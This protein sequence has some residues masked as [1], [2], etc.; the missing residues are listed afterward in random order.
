RKPALGGVRMGPGGGGNEA[1]ARGCPLAGTVRDVA[2]IM[3]A[4]ARH[5]RRDAFALPDDGA[6]YLAE[7]GE[8][9]ARARGGRTPIRI[10]WSPDLGF[11]P[12][13][14]ETRGIARSGARSFRATGL[15]VA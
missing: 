5:D 3:N 14:R 7:G 2:L 4:I 1:V 13:A 15:T 8:P 10:A 11:A 9:L 12:V 6:D